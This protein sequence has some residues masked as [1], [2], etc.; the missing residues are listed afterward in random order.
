MK[1]TFTFAILLLIAITATAQTKDYTVGDVSFRMIFVEGG[2][3]KM[4][5]NINKDEGS[6]WAGEKPVHKVSVSD[7]WMG[8]TEVTQELWYEVMGLTIGQQRDK[9][10]SGAPL[11]GEGDWYPVYYVSWEEAVAFCEK[12]SNMLSDQLPSGYKFALPTE[13]E[14]EY[15][16]RG[17]KRQQDTLYA[18]RTHSDYRGVPRV[19][20]GYPNDLG[21]YDMSGSLFEWCADWYGEDYYSLSPVENPKGPDTGEARVSRGGCWS[22][23]LEWQWVFRRA[24]AN[25][26]DR[27]VHAGFR[28]ALVR[29]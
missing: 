16:A 17:G 20:S 3:F 26:N 4:G 14:W 9:A 5:C 6:C 11:Y 21:L 29:R 7:F 12:L 2:T 24:S 25:P 18:G 19:K 23:E 10:D 28:V 27:A 1:K 22:A 13:A 15:A 8:E